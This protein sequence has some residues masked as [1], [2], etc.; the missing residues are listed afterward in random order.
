MGVATKS[1]ASKNRASRGPS[2]PRTSEGM[3][4]SSQNSG[5]HLIFSGRVLEEEKK[6]AVFL[7]RALRE[8]FRPQ[9]ALGNEMIDDLVINRIRK[10]RI[11]RYEAREFINASLYVGRQL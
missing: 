8:Q 4:R 5:K 3:R 7:T 9:G 10:R 6:D 1:N 2:G 11:D